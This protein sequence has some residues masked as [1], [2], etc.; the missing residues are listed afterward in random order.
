MKKSN[1]YVFV[2]D[3]PINAIVNY[4]FVV[5]AILNNKNKPIHRPALFNL[6]KLYG[7]QAEEEAPKETVRIQTEFLNNQI[8]QI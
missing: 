6:V 4:G 5:K 8:N 3:A 7:K 1:N 2:V